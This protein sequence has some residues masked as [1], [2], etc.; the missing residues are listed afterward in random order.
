MKKLLIVLLLGMLV[1][2]AGENRLEVGKCYMV[3]GENTVLKVEAFEG[4]NTY[5]TVDK[6]GIKYYTVVHYYH[7]FTEVSCKILGE[8]E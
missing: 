1:S 7:G 2:C 4:N 6:D 3:K 8:Q 5:S